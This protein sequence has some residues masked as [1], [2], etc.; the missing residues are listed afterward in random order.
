MQKRRLH[1]GVGLLCMLLLF[2]IFLNTL[3]VFKLFIVSGDSMY[4]TIQSGS[5]LICCDVMGISSK[6]IK[7][8]KIYLYERDGVYIVH[9]LLDFDKDYYYFKGDNVTTV[10]APVSRDI[11]LYYVMFQKE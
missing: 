5:L 4:P 6:A 9:R 3:G 11:R 1:L 8:N 7:L 10:D 2:S